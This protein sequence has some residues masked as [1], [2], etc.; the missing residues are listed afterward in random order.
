MT[1]T[2]DFRPQRG[3]KAHGAA[4]HTPSWLAHPSE[5]ASMN[6]RTIAIVALVIVVILVIVLFVI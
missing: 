6:T 4:N 1:P 2:T 3:G 5:A